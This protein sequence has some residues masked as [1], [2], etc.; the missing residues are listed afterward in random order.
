MQEKTTVKQV[1]AFGLIVGGVFA[2]IGLW[3]L[4]FHAQK[5]HEGA[6]IL[7]LLLVIPAVFFPRSLHPVYRGWM[8][9]GQGLG[10]INTRII[11]GVIFYGL[12]TPVRLMM[13]LLDKDPMNRKFDPN[14][15]SYRVVRQ[16]RPS[17]H[18]QRQF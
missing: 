12:F 18:M 8:M 3:P 7:A 14:V 16:V 15:N 11:L 6:V 9:L 17:S 5:A 13:T 2:L 1:R 10:W 4:L